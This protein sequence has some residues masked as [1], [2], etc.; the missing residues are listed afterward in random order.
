[1]TP[2]HPA[3]LP[4]VT[5]SPFSRIIIQ[6]LQLLV[7]IPISIKILSLSESLAVLRQGHSLLLG[8]CSCVTLPPVSDFHGLKRSIRFKDISHI[9][10]GQ[11]KKCLI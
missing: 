6:G 8:N 2:E 4:L 3:L 5:L 9:P 1:M 11:W 10:M 7:L